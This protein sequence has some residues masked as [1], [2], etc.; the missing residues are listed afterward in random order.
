L[1]EALQPELFH[2]LADQTRLA[3]LMRLVAAEGP[4][5]VTELADCCGVHLSGVSRHLAMLRSA[6]I[7]EAKKHG[8]EVRYSL[9]RTQLANTLRVIADAVDP[10]PHP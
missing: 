9:R 1:Q 6:E 8:R 10:S 7:L 4:Q 5:T 3:L 2:A